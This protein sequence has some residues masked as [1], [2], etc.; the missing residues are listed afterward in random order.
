MRSLGWIDYGARFL[1]P[2][3]ARWNHVDPLA[4]KFEPHSPYAYVLNNPIGNIDPDGRDVIYLVNTDAPFGTGLTGHS[5]VLVGNDKTGWTLFSKS[6]GPDDANGFAQADIQEY[7]NLQEFQ[8]EMGQTGSYSYG[9]RVTT[10]SEEDTDM[11]MKAVSGIYT[12]YAL[13]SNNCAD[14]CRTVMGA[15]G[16]DIGEN[17]QNALG[18]TTVYGNYFEIVGSSPGTNLLFAPAGA[19]PDGVEN[20]LS[21]ESRTDEDMRGRNAILFSQVLDENGN[22]KVEQGTYKFDKDGK[23]QKQ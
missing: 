17:W 16:V 14:F 23:L 15:G 4:E 10:S 3:I 11:E 12:P 19:S 2:A 1:D 18:G 9:Y 7:K 5:A 20:Q 13:L 6:G 22:I 21:E 8:D